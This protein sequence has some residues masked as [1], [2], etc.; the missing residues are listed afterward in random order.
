MCSGMESSPNWPCKLATARRGGY[1]W[2]KESK[3][4]QVLVRST[5]GMT[6]SSAFPMTRPGPLARVRCLSPSKEAKPVILTGAMAGL[7]RRPHPWPG[8]AA[9]PTR[10]GQLHSTLSRFWKG[11]V[12]LLPNK[13]VVDANNRSFPIK[14]TS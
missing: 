13:R 12:H 6:S 10:L 9:P 1:V 7:T 5:V 2:A 11:P 14:V 4:I 3:R 8:P